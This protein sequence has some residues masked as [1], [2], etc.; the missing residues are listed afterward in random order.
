MKAVRNCFDRI[1]ILVGSFEDSEEN[2]LLRKEWNGCQDINMA[3][4]VN[5]GMKLYF[6]HINCTCIIIPVERVALHFTHFFFIFLA[7]IVFKIPDYL[8]SVKDVL[9]SKIGFCN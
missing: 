2:R 7:D 6:L 5:I 1:F 3:V 8:F 4:R 9:I